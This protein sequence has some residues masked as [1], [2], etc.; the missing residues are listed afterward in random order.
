MFDSNSKGH[1]MQ[2]RAKVGILIIIFL[3]ARGVKIVIVRV[4]GSNLMP[5]MNSLDAFLQPELHTSSVR[6]IILAYL[7]GVL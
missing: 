4:S 2:L 7:A 1:C 5:T 6:K 3:T